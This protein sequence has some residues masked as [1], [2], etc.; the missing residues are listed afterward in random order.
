MGG[1]II[2]G[3][4]KDSFL[5]RDFHD[6]E[7]DRASTY[8]SGEVKLF[9]RGQ[10]I[11]SPNSYERKIGFVVSGECEVCRVKHDGGRVTL[12]AITRGGSF[13]ISAVFSEEDF[14][15]V[16]YAKRRSSVVFLTQEELLHLIDDFPAVALNII[17]FQNEKIAF[18]NKKIETF[19]AGS[20]EKKL[21]C[22]FLSE[23]KARGTDIFELNRKKTSE[24]LGIG[25]ASL[26]RALD[27]LVTNGVITCDAKKIYINDRVGLER[28]A[29]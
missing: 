18:L 24:I 3:T 15:T 12:N 13:G 25:R 4:L 16:I 27:A 23:L 22:Y 6:T 2:K 26:Y 5:F 1:G 11:Y 10:E 20:A 9:E 19:S 8:F 21:A 7:Y 17:K 28:I 14:P 29:K